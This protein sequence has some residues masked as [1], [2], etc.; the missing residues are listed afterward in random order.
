MSNIPPLI[1]LHLNGIKKNTSLYEEK[2][3]VQRAEA[4]DFIE[5]EIIA[6]VEHQILKYGQTSELITLKKGGEKAK[7]DLEAV[8]ICLFQSLRTQIKSA[9]HYGKSFINL[10]KEYVDFNLDDG[11]HQDEPGYDNLDIFVNSLLHPEAIPVQTLNLEPEMVYFQKTPVRIV[12]EL[13]QHI[14]F[15]SSDVFFDLGSGLGQVAILVNLLTGI[16]SKGIEFEPA[17]YAYA[18]ACAASFNLQNVFFENIDAR[19]ADY[20]EG[21]IFFMFTPFKG[22]ILQEVLTALWKESVK[23]EIKIVTY[24][25]CTTEVAKQSWLQPA[26]SEVIH[27]YK[28]AIF[29]SL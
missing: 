6:E 7:S 3:F 14:D 18:I 17:F 12:F 10:V 19:K 26:T 20:S 11:E 21:T 2:N 15:L 13:A 8:D 4:I 22:E 27:D 1:I 25:P 29:N 24:G 16:K 9:L 28:L 23:R 5:F